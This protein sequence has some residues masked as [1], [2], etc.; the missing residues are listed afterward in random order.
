[1][2]YNEKCKLQSFGKQLRELTNRARA[3]LEIN[4][5]M[6]KMLEAANNGKD[7]VVFDNLMDDAPTLISNDCLWEWLREN[8][9]NASGA[10]D[11][12]TGK[13]RYTLSW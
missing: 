8:D 7:V 3:E 6:N 5:L 13:Y 12:N 4:T 9:I 10:V 2:S 11:K 1:M